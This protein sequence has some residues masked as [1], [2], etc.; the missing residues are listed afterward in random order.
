[1]TDP[2]A[3]EAALDDLYQRVLAADFPALPEIAIK[4]EQLLQHL[5]QVRDKNLVERLRVKARRNGLCLQA[6][7]RGLRAAQRR[8][9][10]MS[11]TDASLATYTSKGARSQVGLGAGI[12]AQRL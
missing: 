8:L 9:A 3:L 4:T 7:A 6:A 11:S 10:E 2:F 12:L 1:M 5:G